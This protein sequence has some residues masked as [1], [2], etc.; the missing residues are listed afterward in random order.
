MS[1]FKQQNPTLHF[2]SQVLILPWVQ[3]IKNSNL[4]P[5]WVA[6]PTLMLDLS[7]LILVL[8]SPLAHSWLW[9]NISRHSMGSSQQEGGMRAMLGPNI[10]P[11]SEHLMRLCVSFVLKLLLISKPVVQFHFVQKKGRGKTDVNFLG[12]YS[13][14]NLPKRPGVLLKRRKFGTQLNKAT[15]RLP[16]WPN[17]T[18]FAWCCGSHCCFSSSL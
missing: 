10:A 16:V 17:I 3:E 2:P 13:L 4:T 15:L 14:F 5:Q 12:C 1:F 8:L 6:Q 11:A 9:L 18:S 7:C